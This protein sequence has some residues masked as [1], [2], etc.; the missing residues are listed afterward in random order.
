MNLIF[1]EWQDIFSPK[2]QP[3]FLPEPST[4]SLSFHCFP[5]LPFHPFPFL[6]LHLFCL[7]LEPLKKKKDWT[8]FKGHSQS[9][10]HAFHQDSLLFVFP[11]KLLN[12]TKA[13]KKR[14]T[15]PV[16]V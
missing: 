13:E 6:T 9:E 11:Q 4:T 1:F 5:P 8:T 14:H 15:F 2:E 3:I 10:E 16:A 7:G 12:A